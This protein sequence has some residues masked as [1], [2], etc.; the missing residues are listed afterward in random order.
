MK[1]KFYEFY[2]LP[3]EKMNE[4]WETGLLVVDTNVLLDLYRLGKES[5]KDLKNSIDFFKERIWLPYQVCL[6]FHRNRVSIIEQLGGSKFEDYSN[7]LNAEIIPYIKDAFKE[8][9]RH[10]CIDYGFIEEC[11]DRFRK[12][13]ESKIDV[14]K[15]DYPFDS[16]NDEVLQWVTK[17]YEGKVGDDNTIEELLEIYK[18]G[19]VRYKAQ[20]P[21]GYKDFNNKEKKEAGER[22]VYGDL[23]IWKS[24]IAKAKKDKVT[25]IF[26][27]NDN[28]EDWYEKYRGH[29]KGPRFELIREFHKETMQDIILMSEASFLTEMKN[30]TSVSVKDSSITDAERAVN[31]D[32]VRDL[33]K[34]FNPNYELRDQMLSMYLSPNALLGAQSPLSI[35]DTMHYDPFRVEDYSKFLTPYPTLS[36]A[37]Q[38]DNIFGYYSLPYNL[39]LNMS[40]ERVVEDEKLE[41]LKNKPS[42][43]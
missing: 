24:V 16:E 35:N 13:L 4:I 33:L 23:I 32:S 26:L 38:V 37:T 9:L 6:E 11:I 30:R 22:Y 28:K 18:E 2:R 31:V 29:T 12:E 20:V 40:G 10:P 7:R 41:F 39:G 27:T 1:D 8:F 14:W 15:K 5:R 21:P 25:I 34:S 42:S 36:R 3:D 17:K 19:A 43:K